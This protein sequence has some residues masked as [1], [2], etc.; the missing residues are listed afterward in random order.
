MDPVES[1]KANSGD[2]GGGAT[3]E[4]EDEGGAGGQRVQCA[5]Q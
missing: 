2:D 3:G 4:D 5:Q 1:Y